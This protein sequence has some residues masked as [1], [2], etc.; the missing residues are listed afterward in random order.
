[1]HISIRRY[2]NVRSVSEVCSKIG[3]SFV[4]LLKRTP[5]FIAYYAVDGGG[6]SMATVSIFSTEQMAL[7]SNEIA[8]AWLQE[9]VAD[10]Q[11]DPPEIIAGKARVISTA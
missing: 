5:G 9:N 11:P 4:P 7:E 3:T 8:A 10:L 1:M 2:D 6:G